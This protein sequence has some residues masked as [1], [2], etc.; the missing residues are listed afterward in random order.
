MLDISNKEDSETYRENVV[1]QAIEN[2][3]ILLKEI[4]PKMNDGRLLSGY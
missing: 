4:Y 2:T 3:A 1:L